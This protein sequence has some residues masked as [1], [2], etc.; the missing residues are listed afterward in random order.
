MGCTSKN[1][2]VDEDNDEIKNYDERDN[3][4]SFHKKKGK[5][6]NRYK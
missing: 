2:I 1:Q 3:F 5:N 6:N 4:Y